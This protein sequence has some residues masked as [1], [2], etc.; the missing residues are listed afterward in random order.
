MVHITKT[1][2][3]DFEIPDSCNN[4]PMKKTVQDGNCSI[5]F[6]MLKN[7]ADWTKNTINYY[8]YIYPN[9][10]QF[11]RDKNCPLHDEQSYTI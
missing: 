1:Q 6:C 3:W 11:F 4:C 8:K 2:K 10:R 7:D 5:L 9:Q